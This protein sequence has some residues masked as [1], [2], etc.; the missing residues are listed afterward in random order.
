MMNVKIICVG[1]LKEDYL[2]SACAEYEKRL[3]GMCRLTV[4]ELSPESLT[5]ES[6]MGEVL[7]LFAAGPDNHRINTLQVWL[8]TGNMRQFD[9]DTAG[10]EQ[11]LTARYERA[12]A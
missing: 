4:N 12:M 1:K 11:E 3:K 8:D 9:E 5:L 10:A 2:R 7:D 6:K